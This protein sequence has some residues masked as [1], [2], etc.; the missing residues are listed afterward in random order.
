MFKISSVAAKSAISAG[1]I[2]LSGSIAW[3]LLGDHKPR[4]K[5]FYTDEKLVKAAR[6]LRKEYFLVYVMVS[7]KAR[8]IRARLLDKG[9]KVEDFQDRLAT[10]VK[11]GKFAKIYPISVKMTYLAVFEYFL[12]LLNGL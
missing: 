4:L 12:S 5:Q 10:M 8:K 1:I 7:D 6:E 2:A 9:L 3:Y 11:N